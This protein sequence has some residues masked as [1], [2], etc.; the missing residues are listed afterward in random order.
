MAFA[1][2]FDVCVIGS[3]GSGKTSLVRALA[4]ALE[5]FDPF[6]ASDDENRRDRISHSFRQSMA[7]ARNAAEGRGAVLDGC[8]ACELLLVDLDEH[9]GRLTCVI[10]F[11]GSATTHPACREKK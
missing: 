3:P 8:I 4:N 9:H 10:F 6:L 7:A 5:T 2:P 11:P 1:P